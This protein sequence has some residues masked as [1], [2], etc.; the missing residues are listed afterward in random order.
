MAAVALEVER[1]Q[2]DPAATGAFGDVDR[3]VQVRYLGVG[4]RLDQEE[5]AAPGLGYIF[6]TAVASCSLGGQLR[7]H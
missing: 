6:P 1:V 7:P 5:V 2:K 4:D 3:L